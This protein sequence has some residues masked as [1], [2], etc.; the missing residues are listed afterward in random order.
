MDIK[1][2]LRFVVRCIVFTVIFWTVWLFA[3]RPIFYG[4]SDA[5]DKATQIQDDALR[6]RYWDQAQRADELQEK[7]EGQTNQA[8]A[9]LKKQDEL[10]SRWEK[11]IQRWEA[12]A[13]PKK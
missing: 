5:K 1:A 13:P 8:A 11:V 4:P 9:T 7:Y 10:L 6:Q 2:A 3:L 12:A